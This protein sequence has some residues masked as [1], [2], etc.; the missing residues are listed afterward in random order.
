MDLVLRL[1]NLGVSHWLRPSFKNEKDSIEKD[2]KGWD[3]SSVFEH[4]SSVREALGSIPVI[5]RK[6]KR[7]RKRS[8]L[9][10]IEKILKSYCCPTQILFKGILRV[11]F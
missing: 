9:K 4:L 6:G 8:I 10:T 5:T 2:L 3:Y 1:Q 7:E 11:T